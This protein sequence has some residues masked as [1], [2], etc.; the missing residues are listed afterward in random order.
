MIFVCT[1]C[2]AS[3]HHEDEFFKLKEMFNAMKT[4]ILKDSEEL[5]E[6][7]LPTY[8]EI[9]IDLEN[10]ILMENTRNF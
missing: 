3:K 4:H 2:F 1:H 9:A 10:Q 8:E 6:Q 7:I 5:E